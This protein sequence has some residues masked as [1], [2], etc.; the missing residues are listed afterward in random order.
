MVSKRVIVTNDLGLHLRPAGTFCQEALKY[1]SKIKIKKDTYEGNAK[2]VI[3]VLAAGVKKDIE[4]EIICEGSD[5]VEALEHM[6]KLVE[7]GIG[8]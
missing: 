7:T 4:I 2:S 5:E 8:E 1:T 6:V 3:S